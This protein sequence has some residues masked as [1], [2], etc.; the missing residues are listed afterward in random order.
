MRSTGCWAAL[1]EPATR[2]FFALWPD[3]DTA[4]AIWQVAGALVPKGIGRRLPPEHLHITLA[5]LGS[6]KP[7]QQA[8]MTQAADA[9]SGE[10]FTLQLDQPGHFP[11]PQ[12]VWLGAQTVPEALIKLQLLLVERLTEYC[13]YQPEQRA[14]LPHLTLWRKVKR[15]EI[16]QNMPPIAW[17]VQRFVL[18]AS[19]TLPSGAHYSILREWALK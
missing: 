3:A 5:F 12:V 18:A 4:R 14:F 1:A 6:L 10:P 8:C 11:R 19:Q 15:V 17:N 2:L 7:E 9:I 16:P 13:A